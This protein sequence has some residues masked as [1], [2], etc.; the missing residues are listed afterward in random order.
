MAELQ[1]TMGAMADVA[2]GGEVREAADGLF[3]RFTAHGR[4]GRGIFDRRV[5]STVMAAGDPY[6]LLNFG[7]PPDGHLWE[8]AS[9]MLTGADDH[10][11]VAGATP[12]FYVGAPP[13]P[14]G[15]TPSESELVIPATLGGVVASLP[16]YV[17]FGS[18]ELVAMTSE[19]CYVVIYSAP[20]DQQLAGVLRFWRHHISSYL[21]RTL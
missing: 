14:A 11:A 21:D 1:L 20:A 5:A 13:T 4:R 8:L 12:A 16:N 6:A 15:S 3:D 2:S 7:H 10:T 9:L 18:R 17:T 19:R